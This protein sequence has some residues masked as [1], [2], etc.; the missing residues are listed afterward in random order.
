MR[1]NFLVDE[2]FYPHRFSLFNFLNKFC[3]VS[4]LY[5]TKSFEVVLILKETNLFLKNSFYNCDRPNLLTIC[6]C[7]FSDQE[8]PPSMMKLHKIA[9]QETGWLH[10]V[11]SMIK[12]LSD[13]KTRMDYF[14]PSCK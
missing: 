4:I 2:R 3:F 9:D 5:F 13:F 6:I 7:I 8:P 14:F 1:K 11:Q 12:G 10:V